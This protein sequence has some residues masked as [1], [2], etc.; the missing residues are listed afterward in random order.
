MSLYIWRRKRKYRLLSKCIL[1]L[2]IVIILI[3]IALYIFTEET[4]EMLIEGDTIR[5]Q[6]LLHESGKVIELGLEEYVVGVVAAE[7]PAS[8]PLE[9]L[10]A[11]AVAARTYAVKR[12]QIPDPRITRINNKAV[13]SSDSA[14]NQAYISVEEMKS[15]WGK[16]SYLTYKNKITQAVSETKGEVLLYEGNLIDPVY[17]SSCGGCGTEDSE[18]VWKYE[19]PYLRS[20]PCNNHPEGNKEAI[21]IFKLSKLNA[22]MGI[23]SRAVSHTSSN[24]RIIKILEKT[25]SG[26][27]TTLLVSGQ[28][29]SG[30][31][32]RSKL[33]LP[34]TILNWVIEKD[35]IKFISRGY[36]HGVGMCQYG[37][38]SLAKEGKDYGG[39]LKHYYQGV[40]LA[41]VKGR[42]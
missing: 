38:A 8:F 39:I 27:I 35:E 13:L 34:S 7:M 15:R 10:K 37:A 30:A 26:R 6:L 12:I 24:Q 41:L 11:Q 4:H 19:I 20:V 21:N 22:L 3:P 5:V 2:L 25:A 32:L 14:I 23:Q 42:E 33:S 40:N 16:R 36:G 31:E 9:A 1:L 28:E 18:N 17:H 29:V